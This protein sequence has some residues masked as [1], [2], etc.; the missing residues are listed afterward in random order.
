[1]SSDEWNNSDGKEKRRDSNASV[2]GKRKHFSNSG[3]WK[4]R[5]IGSVTVTKKRETTSGKKAAPTERRRRKK[6]SNAEQKK[7]RKK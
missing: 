4:K 6:R 1:M 2:K 3:S 5:I 7:T